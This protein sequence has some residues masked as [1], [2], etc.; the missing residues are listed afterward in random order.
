M[1]YTDSGLQQ[2][3]PMDPYT[4]LSIRYV[5]VITSVNLYVLTIF[6]QW[7]QSNLSIG[8][9][10]NDGYSD[11]RGSSLA[12]SPTPTP[13]PS[14]TQPGTRAHNPVSDQLFNNWNLTSC[15]TEVHKRYCWVCSRRRLCHH[16]GW[17]RICLPSPAVFQCWERD[18][19]ESQSRA[20]SDSIHVCDAEAS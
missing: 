1:Q 8:A 20:D 16:N 11:T 13:T 5:I 3:M 12:I 10:P 6:C 17:W 2:P 4:H 7:G 18:H 19:R 14:D 9:S 15:S